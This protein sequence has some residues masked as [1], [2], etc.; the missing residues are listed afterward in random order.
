MAVDKKITELPVLPS[1][2]VA[3]DIYVN[4]RGGVDYQLTG[5]Q[6]IAFISTVLATG[7]VVTFR[8]DTPSNSSG[9]NG[10]VVIKPTTGQF[11]QKVTGTWILQYTVPAQGTGNTVIYGIG[12]PNSGTGVNGDTYIDTSSGVFYK[13][14]SGAWG[15]VFSMAS[16]PSGPTGPAG[17]NGTNG[18]NGKTILNGTTPPSNT[19]TGIDGDFYLNTLTTVFYG[20]KAGGI[21]PPGINLIN[22]APSLKIAYNY[23][24][25]DTQFVYDAVNLTLQFNLSTS[26][27]A[28]FPYNAIAGI[29]NAEL[30]EKIDSFN[31]KTRKAFEALITNDGTFY[32]SVMFEG[33]DNDMVDN[34]QIV[35]S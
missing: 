17:A 33:I 18:T 10:D 35:L 2:P 30:R 6:L 3:S 7:S 11:W 28:T 4:V 29:L 31:Y 15:Q 25:T 14:T 5:T 21:W 20:P 27:K 16:G 22:N 23:L 34:I 12:F 24:N 26:D 32:T 9:K 13:K 19:D 8:D 1:D